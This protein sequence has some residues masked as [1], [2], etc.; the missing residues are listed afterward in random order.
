MTNTAEAFRDRVAAAKARREAL[1]TTS[2]RE[3]GDALSSREI[4]LCSLCAADAALSALV[5][6]S[7]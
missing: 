6:V 5:R 3:C 7:A 2:C 1:V 4:G